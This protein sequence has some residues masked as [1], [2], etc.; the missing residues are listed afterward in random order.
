MAHLAVLDKSKICSSALH[1]KLPVIKMFVKA[2]DKEGEGFDYLRQKFPK[3]SEEEFS[4][5]HKFNN[6]LNTKT[7]VIKVKVKQYHYRPGQA[8]RVPGG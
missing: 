5:A 6:Y 4:W 1:V 8:L 7:L 3:I 2:M